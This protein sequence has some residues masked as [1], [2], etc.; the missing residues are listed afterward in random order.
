[1]CH[2]PEKDFMIGAEMIH[3][4]IIQ[5][6]SFQ[7]CFD[8]H[9]LQC[10]NK[11]DACRCWKGQDWIDVVFLQMFMAK[12]IEFDRQFQTGSRFDWSGIMPPSSNLSTILSPTTLSPPTFLASLNSKHC[13]QIYFLF[14]FF[15][16]RSPPPYPWGPF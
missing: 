13:H 12:I 4:K 7:Q 8:I 15:F 16:F 11:G 10:K 5:K 3:E 14:F 2:Q 9:Q 6:A 1:M